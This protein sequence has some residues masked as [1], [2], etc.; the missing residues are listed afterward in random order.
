[1]LGLSRYSE[2]YRA[3]LKLALPVALSQ[4]GYVIVQFADNAMVGRYGGE[5]PLPLS[6]VSFGVMISF[7]MFSLSLGITLGI[8]PIIG[9][10]FARGEYR[11]TA[12]YLQ[13]SLITFPIIGL[14]F[15][16]LQLISVPLLYK[17]GQPVEVVDM[18]VPYYRLMAYSLPA[19]MLYGCFKQF[20][21]GMGDTTTPM[22]I[23]ITTNLVNVALN[24][25]FIYGHCGFEAMGVYGAGLATLIARYISPVLIFI[26]FVVKSEC[27]D[28]LKLFSRGVNYI[29][30]T[31]HLLK[32]GVPTAGQ[33]L[34]EGA[35]FV[36]TSVMMGWFGA[37]AI[38]ANQVAMTYGNAAFMLTI[39]LGSAATIRTSRCY[40]L[41]DKEQMR[42]AIVSSFHLAAFWGACV[43]VVF[44]LFRKVLPMAFTPSREIIA[45]ASPMLV[46]VALYQ[47]S[48][49]IQGTLIGVLRGVQDVKIIAYMSEALAIYVFIT[50][51]S[52]RLIILITLVF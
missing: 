19:I 26:Y 6:S 44:V 30:D 18:A 37:E 17:M 2:D 45:L 5:N 20:L 33:M 41:R 3:N 11:R 43:L 24:W 16:V 15:M 13:S 38:A 34:L 47:V 23:A 40:G 25:V 49:A 8:T 42:S 31:Y 46:L 27:R 10:H 32:I 51:T 1:M 48:D 14:L 50:V 12:H 7:V 28:Y 35:A 22:V 29:K 52:Y 36:V 4:L 39:A 9:E 21:E